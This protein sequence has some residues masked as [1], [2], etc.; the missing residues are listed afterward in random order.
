MR[1]LMKLIIL[2]LLLLS[3]F[4]SVDYGSM[5]AQRM[6][7]ESINYAP[8]ECEDEM[9]KY[10]SSFPC[11]NTLCVAK[12]Q[13]CHTQLDC[14]EMKVHHCG[15]EVECSSC[16]QMFSP[17]DWAAHDPTTCV[18][19]NPDGGG[20][21]GGNGGSGGGGSG[22]GGSS[23]GGGGGSIG[24]GIGGSLDG[25]SSM[26]VSSGYNGTLFSMTLAERKERAQRLL[27]NF[28]NSHSAGV[29]PNFSA[30][31]VYGRLRKLLGNTVLINQGKNGTCGAAALSK[32]LLE[33]FPDKYMEMAISLYLYGSYE[34]WNLSVTD[35]MKNGTAQQ[36]EKCLL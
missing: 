24:G 35:A 31:D 14:E 16:H 21:S 6:A 1:K 25:G 20:N 7:D 10:S 5:C 29:F 13:K 18:S 12:C 22:M 32:Y 33:N 27:D 23:S 8:Y 9:G 15:D 36:H 4:L 2:F 34:G 19:T 30:A 26:G 11:E 28:K 3:P 17:A